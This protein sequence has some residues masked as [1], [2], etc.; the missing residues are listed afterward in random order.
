MATL[1]EAGASVQEWTAY[2][3]QMQEALKESKEAQALAAKEKEALVNVLA[4]QSSMKAPVANT[5]HRKPELPPFSTKDIENWIRRVKNAYQRVGISDAKS[6]FA[7]LEN[8]IGS[9]TTPT[10]NSFMV[11]PDPTDATWDAFLDHLTQRYGR[12]TQQQAQSVLRNFKRHGRTPE[13]MW[14]HMLEQVGDLTLQDVLKENLYQELPP[15]VR[16]H[17]S[18]ELPTMTPAALAKAANRFFDRDGNLE[19][20]GGNSVNQVQKSQA[21]SAPPSSNDVSEFEPIHHVGGRPQSRPQ[22]GRSKSRG[23]WNQSQ[24]RFPQDSSNAPNPMTAGDMSL[25]AKG[26]CFVHA[27]F[28]NNAYVDRCRNVKCVLRGTGRAAPV[29][30]AKGRGRGQGNAKGGGR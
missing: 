7:F 5:H 19:N 16:Q 21:S 17:L 3:M 26:L 2:A 28:G 22:G 8:I 30:P 13:D 11:H 4:M 6:K 29:N 18:G 12:T 23:R 9:E 1:P 14:A 24:K 25:N 10:I 27:K 20:A 15:A